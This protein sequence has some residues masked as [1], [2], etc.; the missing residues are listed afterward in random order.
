MNKMYHKQVGLLLSVLPEVAKED[1]F[2]LHGGTAINLF[3][4]NM[5]RLSIDVDLTYT[6]VAEREPSLSAINEA[7]SRIKDR[8]E[9]LLPL[10]RVEHKQEICKLRIN[11]NGTLIKVEVNMV[12]R[13]LLGEVVNAPLCDEAQEQFD[14]FCSVPMV[15]LGQLYGGKLCAALDRQHPR[16]IFDIKLLLENEG[17]NQEI[18]DGL[19]YGLL[20]GSRPIHEMLAPNLIDQSMA[21]ENQFEG[22]TSH[23]FTYADYEET[24]VNMH[25]LVLAS[26]SESD[27]RFLI[28]FNQL[29]P[30]WSVY[31]Y[32][33]F[34][35]V[36]WKILNLNKFRRNDPDGFNRHLD[37]LMTQLKA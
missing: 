37:Q 7:L 4:R 19:I 18:K 13:G 15:A 1:C 35:S 16:D 12:G 8:V 5:P 11:E 34:P 31:P 17:F 36:K 14:V 10:A 27:R 9:H 23:K 21:F 33:H 26:L 6:E 29:E 22:M 20:S 3:V 28:S 32:Q 25:N 30:D 24:R 2:A